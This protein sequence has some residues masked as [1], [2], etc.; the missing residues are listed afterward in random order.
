M[1]KSWN[2]SWSSNFIVAGAKDC[3][4]AGV[5]N[6]LEAVWRKI[7]CGPMTRTPADT[8]DLGTENIGNDFHQQKMWF[9]LIQPGRINTPKWACRLLKLL[10]YDWS[11]HPSDIDIEFPS[12]SACRFPKWIDPRSGDWGRGSVRILMRYLQIIWS[13]RSGTLLPW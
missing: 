1:N 13:L 12:N 8:C 9:N 6:L 10:K 7:C 4:A 2:Q 11:F 3:C 5:A